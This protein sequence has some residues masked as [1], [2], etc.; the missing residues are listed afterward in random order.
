MNSILNMCERIG[1]QEEIIKDVIEFNAI[2]E[3]DNMKEELEKLLTFETSTDARIKLKEKLGE[4]QKGVKIL[5]C[6]IR[7]LEDTYKKYKQ[8]GIAEQIFVDTMNCFPRFI[9]EH[10]DSYGFYGFDRDWWTTRQRGGM[11]MEKTKVIVF[12]LFDTLVHGIRFDFTEGLFYLYENI[13]VEGTDK[14]EFLDYANKYWKRIYDKQSAD[15][16]ELPFEDEL[17]DF[18][19]KFG[20][21]VSCSIEE[22]QYNCAIAMNVSKLFTDTISTLEKLKTLEIPVYL[23]SNTIFKKSVMRKF[24]N[25]YDLEKYFVNTYF[26]ADY[27]V[28]KPNKEFFQIVYDEI[29]KY[30]VTIEKKDIYFV[31][32]NYEADSI[33]ADNFGFTPVFINRKRITG[34]NNKS[35]IEI[36]SLNELLDIIGA[37]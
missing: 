36:H 33:G 22:I 8:L 29:K 5:T 35:F 17:L 28:K 6:M 20:F 31:G 4:D 2:F 19:R 25:Q 13:L 26:S 37:L 12:D 34:I 7:C 16:L 11:C 24:I 30:D 3:Y 9:E 10:K 14:E 1:L 21:K 23:L 18:K 32:D 15:N 27:K